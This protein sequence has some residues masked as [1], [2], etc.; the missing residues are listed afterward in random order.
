MLLKKVFVNTILFF[1][2]FLIISLIAFPI[3][4]DIIFASSIVYF[5]R[6][7]IYSILILNSLIVI[8]VII[9][10]LSLGKDEK[11][12][13]FYRGHEKFS[14]KDKKYES[15][16]SDT[17]FMRFGDLYFVD[18]G[19]NK[20]REKIVESRKQ[21]F[22]TDSYG[23]RN[24]RF[25][26]SES[27]II[28]VGDS[29]ISAQGT[30]QEHMP[31]NILSDIS[32]KKVATISWAGV[33]PRDYEELI[34]KYIKVLKN[35]TKI[36][37]FYFEGN[38][39]EKIKVEEN[40]ISFDNSRYIYW[41]GYKI[42]KWKADI[43]F[44]YERLERNKD[45]FLLMVFSEKN[46]FLRNIRAKTHHLNRKILSSWTNT[47]SPIQYFKIGDKVVGFNYNTPEKTNDN[48][49]TYIPQDKKIIDRINAVFFIPTKTRVY[50]NYIKID[51]EDES[52][53]FKVLKKEF[54]LF[55]IPV[56]DLSNEMKNSVPS[57]L[58]K[59]KYLF[60]RDDTHWNNYGIFVAMNY[61]NK[62]I[63]K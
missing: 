39:F 16:V 62:I 32:R 55:N 14:T 60:W 2:T 19:L 6:N 5:F 42:V 44:A 1:S 34:K 54:N 12:G 22:V 56:Y 7:K 31:A 45:K 46:Y 20:K 37:V 18:G 59:G 48:F 58:S 57:Y 43:R 8:I 38:D 61:I 15:N 40:S 49:S 47:G 25:D 4:F 23:L 26:I 13:Y 9:I 29:F 51:M 33:S 53:K 52:K 63:N 41:R 30:S 10:D 17:I 3:L 50:S 21:K 27:D 35:D 28:L 36:F 24:D 11:Y